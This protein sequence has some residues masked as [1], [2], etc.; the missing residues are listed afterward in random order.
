MAF[1]EQNCG[2]YQRA[3]E[4]I[5]KRWTGLAIMVLLDGPRRFSEIAEQLGGVSDRMLSERL[6]ELEGEGIIERRVFPEMPVR[7]EY[8]LSAKGAALAPV[9]EAVRQWS[10]DWMEGE[11]IV[12]EV[13]IGRSEGE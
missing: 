6:K 5:G 13:G 10:T 9:I 1:I 2:S 3:I 11:S 7:I 8:R 4:L 12:A